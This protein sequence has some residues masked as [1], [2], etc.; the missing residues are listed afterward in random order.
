MGL[1]KLGT[2]ALDGTKVRANA[3]KH[4]AMSYERMQ[5]E[6]RRLE[7][8][9]RALLERAQQIDWRGR[10]V[11]ESLPRSAMPNTEASSSLPRV[12]AQAYM[13]QPHLGG[14]PSLH[15][16]PPDG[17]ST[18]YDRQDFVSPASCLSGIQYRC[19]S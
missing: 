1:V 12:R 16:S 3:S 9:I 6:E 17:R 2:V 18:P 15:F 5:A 19:C 11:E 4:K 10:A 13:H 8:E 7:Q 14:V